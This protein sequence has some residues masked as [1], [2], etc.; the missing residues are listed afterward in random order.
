MYLQKGGMKLSVV[1]GSGK[2]AVVAM[3]GPAIS[4]VKDAW[5]AA[6]DSSWSPRLDF[7]L[8]RPAALGKSQAHAGSAPRCVVGRQQDWHVA[9]A[10]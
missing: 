10:D 3:F 9:S 8:S 6:H 4:S 5:P 1:N 2:E 7:V